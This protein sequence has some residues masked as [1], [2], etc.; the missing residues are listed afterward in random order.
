M[1]IAVSALGRSEVSQPG[2]AVV[3]SLRRVRPDVTIIGLAYDSTES[4]IYTGDCDVVYLMPYPSQGALALSERLD[5]I[6]SR[7]RLDVVIP[8]LDNELLNY[9]AVEG[10]LQARNIRVALPSRTAFQRRTKPNLYKLC[11]SLGL[12][13]PRAFV[14][15]TIEQAQDATE[16]LGFPV[17]L[18]GMEFGA[19]KVA[20]QAELVSAFYQLNALVLVQKFVE[21]EDEYCCVGLGDGYGNLVGSCTI[22]KTTTTATGKAFGGITVNN[23]TINAAVGRLVRALKWCGIFE[24]EFVR[25]KHDYQIFEMNPRAP[26]WLDAAS[27]FGVNLPVA[28]VDMLQGKKPAVKPCEP[29]QLFARHATDITF[30]LADMASLMQKGVMES[31]VPPAA[32]Q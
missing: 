1:I 17:M 11:R 25:D 23:P 22:R 31:V 6:H 9:I 14:A 20:T 4:G 5:D 12:T 26:A 16:K 3:R 15:C 18:K 19:I 21:P 10:D 24:V 28:M 7:H 27:Q 32:H 2:I 30:N 29:G 8:C 13:S